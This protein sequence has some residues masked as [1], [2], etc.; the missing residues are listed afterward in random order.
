MY[1]QGVES[2][3]DLVWTDG[4]LGR[5]TYGDVYHQ[6]EVEQ[7]KFN[8]EHANVDELFKQFDAFEAECPRLL[9]ARLP[10]PAYERMLKTSHTFNLLDSRKAISV[11]ERQRFILRVR[12]LARGVSEAYYASREALGL[13]DAARHGSPAPELRRASGSAMPS[14]QP[15]TWRERL[16]RFPG[17]DRHRRTAAEVA[18]ERS[19]AA[20]ADG[21]AKGLA[22]AGLQ[23]RAVER[24]ATP[25]RLAVRVRRLVEQQ[26]DRPLE[27]RGPPVKASFDAQGAPTQAAL[28]VRARLRRRRRRTARNSRRPRARGSC[29]A[30]PNRAPA[31]STCCPA[32]CRRRSTRCRLRD[33]CA[34]EP[35]KRS[36]CGPCTGLRCCSGVTSCRPRS[37]ACR[38]RT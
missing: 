12:T 2:V 14:F 31:R 23:H 36:S 8:F 27:R 10:L 28:R 34:G 13:P 24:F 37:W 35:A 33:A 18:V 19:S 3:F 9:E 4:P 32:S 11:T 6:N 16:S 1:L 30:A 15:A 17:R 38:H 22:D 7:S 20:F 21:V 26:P 5:V 29:S 25:R